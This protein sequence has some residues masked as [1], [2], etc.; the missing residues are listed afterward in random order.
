MPRISVLM[1]AYNAERYVAKAIRSALDSLPSDGEVAVFDD[2]S[3][4]S[5]V[6]VVS[7]IGDSRVRLIPSEQNLGLAGALRQLLA[8]TDSEFVARLDADDLSAKGRFSY[9]EE[10]LRCTGADLSF[11]TLRH[12]GWGYFGRRSTGQP[13]LS[14]EGVQLSLLMAN[15]LGH[16][17]M[18]GKRS[19]FDEN[20]YPACATEDYATWLDML[21][22]GKQIVMSDRQ[23]AGYRHHPGQITNGAQWKDRRWNDQD[24]V[25]S[26]YSRLSESVLG[27]TPTHTH[28]IWGSWAPGSGADHQVVEAIDQRIEEF[29]G[30]ERT[31]LRSLF[32][33]H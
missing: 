11:G 32:G 17:T 9:Q 30:K 19:A 5:T 21:G 2:A 16:S 33:R 29:S 8:R 14:A 24:V 22:R 15:P 26:A 12:F 4:D 10:E 3:T 27:V 25:R 1:A 7:G 6:D 13:R 28:P 23:L 18:F 31:Y 20:S